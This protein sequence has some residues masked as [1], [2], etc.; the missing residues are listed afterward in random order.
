M[1]TTVYVSVDLFFRDWS[2]EG[3][4]WICV[5]PHVLHEDLAAWLDGGRLRL[6]DTAHRLATPGA[7]TKE[8]RDRLVPVPLP[9]DTNLIV[10]LLRPSGTDWQQRLSDRRSDMVVPDD[11]LAR[12]RF[13]DDNDHPERAADPQP[14]V[15][16]GP[17]AQSFADTL[18]DAWEAA[19]ARALEGDDLAAGQL[20]DTLRLAFY[21]GTTRWVRLAAAGG[22]PRT[23]A[24]ANE[25]ALFAL[26][27]ENENP[28]PG[29]TITNDQALTGL[30]LRLFTKEEWSALPSA[31]RELRLRLTLD[32]AGQQEQLL[33][34]P[35]GDAATRTW[36]AKLG[37]TDDGELDQPGRLV[38]ATAG[39]G[40][41][42]RV[43]VDDAPQAFAR[44]RRAAGAALFRRGRAGTG[45]PRPRGLADV[46]RLLVADQ[47][48]RD[49]AP[50]PP[51]PL[52]H[53]L[54]WRALSAI[55][56]RIEPYRRQQASGGERCV[57]R[58]VPAKSARGRFRESLTVGSAWGADWILLDEST[59]EVEIGPAGL[60]WLGSFALPWDE[61]ERDFP[62][63]LFFGALASALGEADTPI[64]SRAVTLFVP[65]HDV[66]IETVR[67]SDERGVRWEA[68]P[69]IAPPGR[70]FDALELLTASPVPTDDLRPGV[71]FRDSKTFVP[72]QSI[73]RVEGL[74][75]VHYTGSPPP[76]GGAPSPGDM[77]PVADFRDDV[78]NH[79]AVDV[80]DAGTIL[81]PSL[82]P[83]AELFPVWAE[84]P[85][86]NGG[87][88]V[89][90]HYRF[91]RPIDPE[92][93]PPETA[94]GPLKPID[95]AEVRRTFSA[96]YA[97]A[98]SPLPL[99]FDLLHIYGTRIDDVVP[100]RPGAAR[101]HLMPPMLPSE[102]GAGGAD[103]RP[104]LTVAFTADGAAVDL[105][106]RRELLEDLP[107]G[108]DEARR[109]AL[110]AAWRSLYELAYADRVRLVA[111]FRRFDHHEMH[112]RGS[113]AP[114]IGGLVPVGEWTL[115]L[116][117]K[118][119]SLGTPP[120]PPEAF[121]R[122]EL[123][124]GALALLAES[125]LVEF[126]LAVDRAATTFPPAIPVEP[127]ADDDL[128]RIS[129]V[130]NGAP[131]LGPERF[132]RGGRKV[133]RVVDRDLRGAYGDWRQSIRGR[134]GP[135]RPERTRESAAVDTIFL[136]TGEE[137][138][139]SAWIEPPVR[140]HAKPDARVAAYPLGFVPLLPHP[141]FGEATTRV[142]RRWFDALAYVL[143]ATPGAWC[144]EHDEEAWR[145]HFAALA[146]R[147][148][149]GATSVERLVGAALRTVQPAYAADAALPEPLPALL[150]RFA[151]EVEPLLHR[152]L[153]AQAGLFGSAKA[154]LL[155]HLRPRDGAGDVAEDLLRLRAAH[156]VTGAA[157]A[158]SLQRTSDLRDALRVPRASGLGTV[159][160][161]VLDDDA[162]DDRFRLDALNIATFRSLVDP[163]PGHQ[164]VV[165]PG[166]IL[167]PSGTDHPTVRLPS[168]EPPRLP[169]HVLTGAVTGAADPAW[170]RAA[171]ARVISSRQLV[172]R[173][174]IRQAAVEDADA[175]ERI[176]GCVAT[177]PNPA[178]VDRVVQNAVFV[179][180]SNEDGEL[181]DD[182]LSLLAGGEPPAEQSLPE[183]PPS[184]LVRKLV[185]GGELATILELRDLIK[186]PGGAAHPADDVE[187]ALL[188][189]LRDAGAVD[190]EVRRHLAG[191]AH[192]VVEEPSGA[193]SG[194]RFARPWPNQ[195]VVLT[196]AA[197]YA[198]V[199]GPAAGGQ[200]RTWPR[201]A[202]RRA[203]LIATVQLPVWREAQIGLLHSRNFS[204]VATTEPAFAG[205][206]GR[207]R[208]PSG[209]E[210]KRRPVASTALPPTVAPY[211]VTSRSMSI[212]E[213]VDAALV[214]R[215]LIDAEQWKR[216]DL[217]VT[218]CHCQRVLL[219]A[220]GEAGVAMTLP[221]EASG[222]M[223]LTVSRRAAGNDAGA[224][225][226][227]FPGPYRTF[228][229]QLTWQATNGQE[230]F[231]LE[232][233]RAEA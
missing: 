215:G 205:V 228:E 53:V 224:R 115:D 155:S 125:D 183:A 27:P 151:A 170:W 42:R 232:R 26:P 179:V 18:G 136:S 130:R 76:S 195:D 72:A 131:L 229:L 147:D 171:A 60:A 188:V 127:G 210:V 79:N 49:D 185:A 163:D 111:S 96:S 32:A 162:Y 105:R 59:R 121:W 167:V 69:R 73:A 2:R 48:A 135:I 77:D 5:Q 164:A 142:V 104:F 223:P 64:V 80:R 153:R 7:L 66:P 40:F 160:H 156:V 180:W 15:A 174:A 24:V 50:P 45:D 68:E 143:E 54:S 192:L 217:V 186:R 67:R 44:V 144:D 38:R 194:L 176:G 190:E 206:F 207:T 90:F 119:H 17:Y 21:G 227:L 218:V 128:V 110:I 43:Y 56:G 86:A 29:V 98:G 189:T 173:H 25:P 97:G 23:L 199:S 55:D 216:F 202:P 65:C 226:E 37:Q 71:V 233:V 148:A 126:H 93:M 161:D 178:R 165:P 138:V 12:R 57:L 118:A 19:K 70:A 175:L 106:F 28:L 88:D 46:E 33:P 220:E 51:I 204:P 120:A 187:Q 166:D 81:N 222:L 231:R 168:R 84:G 208:G 184:E 225:F 11:A 108:F 22:E 100:E 74:L 113:G 112:G 172:E 140:P 109:A 103:A 78:K 203:F 4:L 16:S 129:F 214:Q 116:T 158:V 83:D 221:S 89:A 146:E 124:A 139:G 34:D 91:R 150:G 75:N 122:A 141:R 20:A 95:P 230:F 149:N 145:A 14:G 30:L 169:Q 181:V 87:V 107:Q 209:L 8:Q 6:A 213:L 132:D 117:A 201:G 1:P 92:I 198:E 41:A 134:S 36:F 137:S 35:D 114:L 197:L 123:D 85:D 63:A 31:E 99:R 211:R 182:T 10:R 191:A 62:C 159:L 52:G 94:D 39:D 196:A 219:P 133:E 82:H 177:S 193:S 47:A 152:R 101:C 200:A 3:A 157:G 102:A 61:P 58:F 212:D 154:I 9:R 13:D